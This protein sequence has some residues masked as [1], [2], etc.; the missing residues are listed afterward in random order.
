[1]PS[2]RFNK[3]D[4]CCDRCFCRPKHADE[5]NTGDDVDGRAQD[6]LVRATALCHR[7]DEQLR[8]VDPGDEYRG[9][10]C[11]ERRESMEWRKEWVGA[12]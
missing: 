1:M 2:P 12:I 3:R 4:G 6:Q 7:Q 9:P 8:L 11:G 5:D 10:H